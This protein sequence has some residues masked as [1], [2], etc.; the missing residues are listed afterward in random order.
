MCV[1]IVSTLLPLK[2]N[3]RNS[4]LIYRHSVVLKICVTHGLIHFF[5]W[6]SLVDS[7]G[8]QYFHKVGCPDTHWSLPTL[9]G[10]SD[11]DSVTQNA[12]ETTVQVF[13]SPSVH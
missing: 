4:I 5:Q 7:V 3:E 13:Y 12:T 10:V 2:I 1:I 6:K 9:S 11:T 8:R